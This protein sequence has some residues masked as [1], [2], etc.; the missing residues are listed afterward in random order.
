MWPIIAVKQFYQQCNIATARNHFQKD[1]INEVLKQIELITNTYPPFQRKGQTKAPT[2]E[3]WTY[4]L[5]NLTILYDANIFLKPTI[6]YNWIHPQHFEWEVEP[7]HYFYLD[8]GDYV[9]K[10][11]SYFDEWIDVQ[12][13]YIIYISTIIKKFL[14][15]KGFD[16]IDQEDV[17]YWATDIANFEH[18]LVVNINKDYDEITKNA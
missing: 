16:Q 9:L 4:L 3:T 1:F 8:Q 17:N 15:M 10:R 13:N 6:G 18:T 2:R 7:T 5:S 11:K 12:P 14:I